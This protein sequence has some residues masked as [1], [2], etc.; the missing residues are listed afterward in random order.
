MKAEFEPLTRFTKEV[1]AD[2]VGMRI[3]IV[4]DW[5]VDSATQCVGSTRTS[6]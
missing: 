4:S 2:K 3:V 6:R 1:F 5:V